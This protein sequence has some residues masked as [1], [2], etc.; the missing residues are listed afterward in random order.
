M[1]YRKSEDIFNLVERQLDA[2]V[3][4]L[5]HVLPEGSVFAH[6]RI[7]AEGIRKCQ[8][9]LGRLDIASRSALTKAMFAKIED[10][11]KY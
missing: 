3:G 1:V 11:T 9:R 6:G 4:S 10:E 2:V 5:L 8:F 7:K